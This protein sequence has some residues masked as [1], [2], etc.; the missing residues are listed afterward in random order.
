M[1]MKSML[2]AS[3]VLT[4]SL[5]LMAC[6]NDSEAN[7]Q[8]AEKPAD[9]PDTWIADRT[10]TGLVFQSANDA[11]AGTM[12]PEI[13]DYIKERTGITLEI[14]AVTNEDSQA[15]LASGLAAGD[16]PDFIAFYLNDSGRPEFPMLLQA[17]NEGMFHDISEELQSG[18]IYGKYFEDGYLPRD[19]RENIMMRDDHDG[20]TY[21]VHMAI[22]QEPADPGQKEIGGTYIRKDIAEDLGIDPL[23]V[24]TSE[25]LEDLLNDI[26]DGDYT[27]DNGSPVT[28]LGPTVWGGSD[29]PWPYNDLVWSGPSN[30]KFMKDDQGNILHE[31]MTDYAEQRVEFVRRLLDQGLMHPEFFTMEETRANEGV[32]N[33]SFAVVA[34]VHNYRPELSDGSYVPLGPINRADGSNHMVMPYKSGYA[35]W[36][37]PSTTEN[38]EEIV[39]FAD[40]MASE[41]GKR[42]YMYGLEGEHYDLDEDGKPVVKEE[43]LQLADEDPEAAKQEG[44]R[45][46]GGYWGE[47]LAWTDMNNLEQFG[48][49]A[50]GES[51]RDDVSEQAAR[52]IIDFYNY[53]ERYDNKEVIDGLTPRAYLFE[54]E[55]GDDTLTTALDTWE[56]DIQKAYYANSDEEAQD[57][58]DQMRS[59]LE[60]ANIEE[61]TEFLKEKEDQ[62]EVIFY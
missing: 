47:H 26:K 57:I 49:A 44:F 14:E 4:T 35:G 58:I 43:M 19:T 45:G 54:F 11:G 39:Q 21:L 3:V 20:A 48:E 33:G 59:Q 51:Q 53:D 46:V 7:N 61:F 28:P 23:E 18:E 9:A 1:K 5:L 37:V 60:N 36:A 42:L 56:E 27:D 13:A 6:G 40:W 30:E 12:S 17:S 50:W 16:L 25:E 15:A 2:K 55:D 32:T 8:S 24:N 22:D 52:D 38:P 62:G 41:E 31:S 34:D 10:I 29:R